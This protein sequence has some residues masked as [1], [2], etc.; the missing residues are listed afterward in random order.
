MIFH[1]SSVVFF[2]LI[3]ITFYKMYTYSFLATMFSNSI[4][5]LPLCFAHRS[6]INKWATQL[7]FILGV[8]EYV[9]HVYSVHG[10]LIGESFA[11]YDLLLRHLLGNGGCSWPMAHWHRGMAG[12]IP[13]L[14]CCTCTRLQTRSSTP[15]HPFAFCP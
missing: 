15:Y 3:K 9:L 1:L 8:N 10:V 4:R 12:C 6:R 14:Q 5:N 2:F 7:V 13:T 11:K